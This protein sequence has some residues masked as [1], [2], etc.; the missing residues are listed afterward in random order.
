M[1]K[2]KVALITGASSQIGSAIAL[3]LAENNCDIVLN[4]NTN[5]DESLKTQEYIKNNF[6]VECILVKCDISKEEEIEKMMNLI[7]EKYEKLDILIN[8]A[9][10]SIDSLYQNKTKENFM[11]TLETNLVG[12]F[13]VSKY[14]GN[15]M[16]ENRYGKI[17]NISSTNGINKNYPMCLD[18]DAS[19]AGLNSLTHNLALQY[20]PYINV[21]AVALGFIGTDSELKDMDQ[22][23][24]NQEQEKIFLKRYG[25]V[26]D[27]ANVVT[28]L[29]TEKASYINNQ[30]IVVDGGTY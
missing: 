5:Y 18:Y 13:L 30:I 6:K 20:A 11:K 25:T 9:A 4:Y 8:N 29:T 17:I 19:K 23:F 26:E 27:V 12:T 3:H 28:F 7:I 15:I 14:A 10:I 24:I 2:N 21:N 1:I 22:E 16:F